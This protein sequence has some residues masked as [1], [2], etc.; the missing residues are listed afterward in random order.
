MAA[1]FLCAEALAMRNPFLNDLRSV[2]LACEGPRQGEWCE[3]A[4]AVVGEAVRVPVVVVPA[5]KLPLNP[6]GAPAVNDAW[7]VVEVAPDG[8][9]LQVRLD[10]GSAMKMAGV[11]PGHASSRLADDV[12]TRDE[13]VWRKILAA[14]PF[15]RKSGEK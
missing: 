10:W 9:E 8:G 6:S 14:T 4:A 11:D 12:D 2:S 7:L 1:T 5:A 15:V 13:K 3:V